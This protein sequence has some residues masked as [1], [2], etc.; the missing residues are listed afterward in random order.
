[1]MMG[2]SKR[3]IHTS[4]VISA[5]SPHLPEGRPEGIS[6]RTNLYKTL[7]KEGIKY[8]CEKIVQKYE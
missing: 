1:M 8:D 3:E 6:I 2:E 7:K 5:S 4:S